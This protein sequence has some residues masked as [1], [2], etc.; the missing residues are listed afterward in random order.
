M[1]KKTSNCIKCGKPATFWHG[2]VQKMEKFVCGYR[3]VP[4][5]A[6]F[7]DAHFKSEEPDENGCFGHYDLGKMGE[8]IPLFER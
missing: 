8:C 4:V 3:P 5:V 1:T 6:G 2:H 7:C